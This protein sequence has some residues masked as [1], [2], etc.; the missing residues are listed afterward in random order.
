MAP[1][2]HDEPR[3]GADTDE[4]DYELQGLLT[5]SGS[6]ARS[7]KGTIPTH[8]WSR[9]KTVGIA[10]SFIIL[11][12]CG[13]SAKRMLLASY[14][15]PS[16]SFNGDEVRSNGTHDFKRTVLI[17]S[18]D[19]LRCVVN[20]FIINDAYHKN[21]ADY[22]DRGLTP[23]LLDISKKGLRAKAM[24]PIFPVRTTR[25]NISPLD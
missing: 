14:Y 22:L 6:Q 5:G 19:G 3:H 12:I 24:K 10:L 9:S 15:Y 21:R 18:I 23:H 13:Y 20:M 1:W 25:L 11:L 7:E 8:R 17:V 16:S 4:R 2:I